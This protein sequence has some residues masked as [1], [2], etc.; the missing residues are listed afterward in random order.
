MSSIDN[1]LEIINKFSIY[2]R[3]TLEYK[4]YFAHVFFNHM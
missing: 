3:E 2:K 1:K 4:N